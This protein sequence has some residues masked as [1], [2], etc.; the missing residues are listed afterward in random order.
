[1]KISGYRR[2][3]NGTF[4]FW[5]LGTKNLSQRMFLHFFLSYKAILVEWTGT[6]SLNR[7][8]DPAVAWAARFL[9]VESWEDQVS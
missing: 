8:L 1:M 3:P 7:R 4:C 5:R 6:T 2:W 9:E